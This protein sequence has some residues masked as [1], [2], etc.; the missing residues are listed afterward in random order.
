[1][2]QNDWRRVGH[3]A[4]IP[5]LG[6]RRVQVGDLKIAIF[7]TADDQFFALED[8]CPH[9]GGP[10][11]EGI[12]HGTS[13]TCPLH[14]LVVGLKTGESVEPEPKCVKSCQVA[15]ADGEIYLNL[16]DLRQLIGRQAA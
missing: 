6:A 3:M 8:R 13:V 4:D 1:M 2:K 16:A 11:S 15:L 14:N 10:L 12:V 5:K 7:R 9:L